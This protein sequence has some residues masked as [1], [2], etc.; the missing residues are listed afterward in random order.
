MFA[1]LVEHLHTVS[2]GLV[3]QFLRLVQGV[4]DREVSKITGEVVV[5]TPGSAATSNER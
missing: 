5:L 2:D 1:V 4:A 3:D